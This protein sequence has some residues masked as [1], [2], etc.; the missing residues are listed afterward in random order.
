MAPLGSIAAKAE[1]ISRRRADPSRSFC[2]RAA[3]SPD[4][5]LP[6]RDDRLAAV[7]SLDH[8]S[9]DVQRVRLIVAIALELRAVV[10]AGSPEAI[11]A[12]LCGRLS[13]QSGC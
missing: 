10:L 9:I 6:C 1:S 5:L 2:R 12:I 3:P 4:E 8:G 7:P 13:A 11:G